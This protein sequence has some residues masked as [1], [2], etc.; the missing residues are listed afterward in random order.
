MMFIEISESACA[1]LA[2]MMDAM[3]GETH[4]FVV[5]RHV[6]LALATLLIYLAKM[7][8]D[9]EELF[10]RGKWATIQILEDKVDQVLRGAK[11]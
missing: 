5:C 3:L 9:S 10:P 7:A 1:G 8:D 6:D 11:K 2:R 4:S